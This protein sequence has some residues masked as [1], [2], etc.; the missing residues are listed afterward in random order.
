M[1]GVLALA[2]LVAAL[3]GCGSDSSAG[4]S[5]DTR[6]TVTYWPSGPHGGAKRTWTLRCEPAGG[7]LPRPAAAC[8]K[9]AT[10]PAAVA[11]PVPPSTVCAQIYG[12][13]QTARIIGT[14]EG[15]RVSTAFSRT[16]G[17][18]IS[19]W[20]TLSPWLLPRGGAI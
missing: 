18:E 19:R 16:N 15:E 14:V 3:A 6:L 12:G 9:L 1:R 4:T 17:C 20:D 11:E 8:R 7:S 10:D 13:P 2:V 5:G